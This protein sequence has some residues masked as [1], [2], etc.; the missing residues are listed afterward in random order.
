MLQIYKGP[1]LVKGVLHPDEARTAVALGA[2]GIIVSNHGGR[3]L[4]GTPAAI[5][6]LPA[7]VE[8]V[9]GKVPVML[10]GGVRRG[11]DVLK[12]CAAGASAV[13]VGRPALWGLA[14]AGERGVLAVL[15]ILADEAERALALLGVSAP[16][17]LARAGVVVVRPPVTLPA[18]PREV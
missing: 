8:A 5:E 4:D 6:A 1:L 18:P 3:Q 10:D 7:V 17:E 12:A 15:D 11:S 16:S 2:D 14:I 9:G 13:G